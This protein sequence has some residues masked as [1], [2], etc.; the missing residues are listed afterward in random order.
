V[1]LERVDGSRAVY[2]RGR[3]PALLMIDTIHAV[4]DGGVDR[5]VWKFEGLDRREDCA[6]I[7]EADGRDVCIS[8][9][10]IVLGGR[11]E[12]AAVRWLTAAAGVHGLIRFAVGRTTWLDTVMEWR[13]HTIRRDVAVAPIATRFREWAAAF[14]HVS[15]R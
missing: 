8:V 2:H 9:R 15:G 11:Q 4:E 13:A 3:R 7:V 1:Q 5:D 14:E 6:K 10:C 12:Q